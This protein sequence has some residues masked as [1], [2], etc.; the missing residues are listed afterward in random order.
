MNDFR[1]AG[2]VIS[3]SPLFA[4]VAVLTLGLGVGANSAN[5]SVV[6]AVLL[7]PLPFPEPDQLCK[8]RWLSAR[9]R[10]RSF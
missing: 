3:R 4:A 5:F 8:A 7:R 2:R 9:W 1:Y 10:W 6:N